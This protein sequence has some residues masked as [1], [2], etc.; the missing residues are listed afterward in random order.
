LLEYDLT[1]YKG[2]IA[3]NFVAQEL[4]AS[5]VPEVA[6]LLESPDGII[7]IEVKAGHITQSR[8][9]K[10]YEERYRPKR[11]IV[12]SG[13]NISSRDHGCTSRSTRRNAADGLWVH[14]PAL[15]SRLSSLP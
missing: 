2:Y 9:L 15:I 14:Q 4:R 3:E 1:T 11:S 6:F 13:R 5:D 7:A 10:V 12:L 8:S